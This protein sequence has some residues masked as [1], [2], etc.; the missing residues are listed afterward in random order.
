MKSTTLPYA[1][2]LTTRDPRWQTAIRS[3]RHDF[4]HHRGY[5]EACAAHERCEPLLF[6]LD[7]GSRGMLAPLLKR[8]LDGFGPAYRGYHDV[9][10]PY[11]FPGPLYWG[12]ED[13]EALPEM[14]EVFDAC[15][16]EQGVVCL[17]LRL[18][19]FVGP[20][21]HLLAR[22]GEV[23]AHGPTVYMDLRDPLASWRGINEPNRRFITKQL[24]QG[25]RVSFDDW[26]TLDRVVQAYRE[27]MARLG[28]DPYYFFGLEFFRTLRETAG[29]HFHLATSYSPEGEITGG[30]FFTEVQ[31][32]MHYF[33]TGT[34]ERFAPLS[35]SKLL[36]N[37]LRL[38][39]VERGHHTLDLGG[40][41]GAREDNLF[42]FK[43]RMAKT[44]ATYCIFRKVLLPHL[45]DALVAERQPD[46]DG[47]FPAYR[48]RG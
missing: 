24:R 22:A 19:P 43:I 41:L 42:A 38:W 2:F 4:F 8:P 10:S 15:L 45:Y 48:R 35:P 7:M 25:C 47:F 29:D 13:P 23:R 18:N 27:T 12:A 6:Y 9:T 5:L 21:P 26:S 16:R 1:G 37:A 34:F 14:H 17:F 46:P 20:D 36:V 31:G 32:L 11:G 40:G 39:G 28:A 44:C 30:A 3:V 33:L